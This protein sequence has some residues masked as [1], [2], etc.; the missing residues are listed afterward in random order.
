[1]KKHLKKSKYWFLL[2]IVAVVFSF[3]FQS[4]FFEIA[5]QIEIYTTLF[6]ELNIYYIDEIDPAD[7]TNKVIKNT[8]S[9]LDPYTNYFDENQVE[10]AKIRRQG[11]YAGIGVGVF[12]AKNGI[13]IS[14]VYEG[15]E[16]DKKGLQIA[17]VIVEV[18]GVS[19]VGRE[20]EELSGFLKGA[21]GS[22]VA[23]KYKRDGKMLETTLK[24]EKVE[25]NPVPF[26]KMVNDDVGYLTLTR[27][28][29]KASFEVRKAFEN[30]KSEGMKKLIFDL[31]GNP[32]GSLG[33][34]IKISNFFLPK[35]KVIVSTQAKVKKWSN[36][37]KA[38]HQPLDLE[39]PIVVLIDQK[40]ASASEIVSG[41]IQDY[42]RG[43]V[44]GVRSFGKGL[45]QRYRELTYGTQLK[46]TISKYFTPS[47]RCIQ[48]L[49]YSRRNADG[50]VP[51]FSENKM[52]AFK[53]QNGRVVY[54]GGGVTPDIKV[55]RSVLNN[56]TRELFKKRSMF[57]FVTEAQ[58]KK[59]ESIKFDDFSKYLLQKD[60]LTLNKAERNLKT[61][62]LKEKGFG[63]V[64]DE[65]EALK[66]ALRKQAIEELRQNKDWILPLLEEDLFMRNN[67]LKRVFNRKFSNDEFIKE[68]LNVLSNENRYK[69]TLNKV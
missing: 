55:K 39:I 3:S 7:L 63:D 10:E 6:K 31:R 21:A 53:T 40:S 19:T 22:L 5:K 61:S 28:N 11:E 17:D 34:A 23:I 56:T 48:E 65:V 44:V 13:T 62:F 2:L 38:N 33:E 52:N 43:V 32:G 67:N 25:Y 26:Y 68:A 59:L 27:F 35:G 1:M 66:M 45:V 29:E 24:R 41:A 12:Y 16:A 18:D 14:D 9:G 54:D 15:F 37:Y 47:G 58:L 20:V 57:N 4:K 30:L 60:T 69:K 8:L 42:D 64:K 51:K 50:S 46:L 36:V 49:D